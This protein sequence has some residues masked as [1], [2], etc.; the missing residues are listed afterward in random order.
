MEG[1]IE[2]S[3]EVDEYVKGIRTPG[4][5]GGGLAKGTKANRPRNTQPLV[6]DPG[7]SSRHTSDHL[8][9][10]EDEEP[11]RLPT[12]VDLA[13]SFLQTEPDQERAELRANVIK[14]QNL[15]QSQLSEDGDEGVDTGLGMGVSL[16]GFLADFLKGVG[17]RLQVQIRGIQIDLDLKIEVPSST[18][19]TISTHTE[20][21][22][23]RLSVEHIIIDGVITPDID[24]SPENPQEIGTQTQVNSMNYAMPHRR[25]LISNIRGEILSDASLFAN[26]SHLSGPPSPVMTR[27][28]TFHRKPRSTPPTFSET[29]SASSSSSAGLAMTQST[30]LRSAPRSP[31]VP[32]GL[33]ASMATSDGDRFAD[34]D[35]IDNLEYA[36]FGT[37]HVVYTPSSK[38]N[39]YSR[40]ESGEGQ[41]A[42]E[43]EKRVVEKNIAASLGPQ[44]VYPESLR[45]PEI[46]DSADSSASSL[47][48]RTYDPPSTSSRT[49]HFEQ[50][51]LFESLGSI[52]EKLG[53]S[54]QSISEETHDDLPPHEFG[55]PAHLSTRNVESLSGANS[56]TAHRSS[57]ASQSPS[58][59][60]EDLAQSKI[61][62]HDEAQSLYMSA[63]SH[64]SATKIDEESTIGGLDSLRS[65]KNVRSSVIAGAQNERED[66]DHPS[67]P[68]GESKPIAYHS[69][70]EKVSLRLKDSRN[71]EAEE[72]GVKLD[73]GQPSANL[74]MRLPPTLN[75]QVTAAQ[76]ADTSQKSNSSSLRSESP[77]RIVKQFLTIDSVILKIPQIDKD[78]QN[79]D[80]NTKGKS[81]PIKP[82]PK[83][84]EVPG[85][86]AASTI[87]HSSHSTIQEDFGYSSPQRT[88]LDT[89]AEERGTAISSPTT[90]SMTIVVGTV[91]IVSDM[92]LTRLIVSATQQ[93]QI[94]KSSD[95]IP[96]ETS[97]E[98]KASSQL[99]V[100]QADKLLWKF[101]D[102]LRGRIDSA[103]PKTEEPVIELPLE[104]YET[105][106][107][108][109]IKA[110][111][112]SRSHHSTS[113]RTELSI[114]SFKFGYESGNIVSFDSELKMRESTHEE[115]LPA[116]RDMAAIITQFSGSTRIHI[117][118]LPLLVTLDLARL[119][120]T[121]SWFGGLSSVLG[122]GS[123]MMSSVTVIDAKNKASHDGTRPRG[124]RFE[125]PSGTD[126]SNDSAE[127]VQYKVETRI[128]GVLFNLQG[129]NSALRLESTA[130]KLVSR[131]EYVA[132]QVDRLKLS[133]PHLRDPQG[134]PAIVVQLRNVRTEYLTNP[135]EVD[136]ARLLALLSP[137]R[138]KYEPDD[139][140][141]LDTLLRQRRQG[142]VIR[143]TVGTF[144]GNISSLREFEYFSALGEE[145]TKLST[146]TKYL[147]EDDRP[148]IL[149]L[150]LVRDLRLT[151]HINSNFGV[152]EVSSHNI[153]L[154][155]VT[156]PSLML[157]GVA[158]LHI[159]RGMHEE[160]IGEA[161]AFTPTELGQLPPMIM[162]RLI[163]GELE[164]TI[165]VKLWNVRAEYHVATIMAILGVSESTT[166]E[167]IISDLINSVATLTGR[168][169]PPKLASQTSSSSG[170]SSSGS[171]SLRYDVAIRD[172]IVGLNPRKS[173]SKAL[174]VLTNTK[175]AGTI[176]NNDDADTSSVLEIQKASLMI[177]DNTKHIITSGNVAKETGQ[178]GHI[179]Q[180]QFFARM[181]Y[182]SISEIAAAKVSLQMLSLGKEGD[183]SVDVEVRD[184]LF[185]LESCADST[186]TLISIL[187]GL[188]PPMPP[189]RDLKYRTEVI[190]VQ[191]MLASF[192]GNAFATTGT[193]SEGDD[194]YALE[195]EEEDIVDDEVPQN[196]EFVSSFYNP[197]HTSP[198]EAVAN[199][200]LEDDLNS[201]ASPPTTRNIGDKRLLE[202]F[203]EQYE[204]APGSEPLEFHEDHF[205]VGSVIGGTAHKWDSDRNS[206][207]LTNEFKIRGS[208]LRVRVRDVHIIWNL[209]DGYDWQ[210][211]RDIISQAVTEVENKAAERLSR[212]GRRKAQDM[213]EEEDSVIGDF[214]FNSIYI[215]VPA[216]RDPRDLTRQVNRNI[217]DLTSETGSYA[218]STTAT[219]SPNRQG[220]TKRAKRATLRLA[221]SK[222]HKM[223]FELK[224]VAVDLVVFAP[225]S[226]ETESS[227]DVRVQDLE[228]FDLVTTSTWR[229]FATYMHDAGERESGTSMVHIEILNVKP[230][231]DLAASEIILK[232]SSWMIYSSITNM[233]Q[234]TVLPLRLHVDQDALD[235][236]TRF[237]EFKDDSTLTTQ[238]SA[239][240]IPFLQRVEVNSIPVKLD[241]K[242]KRVDYAGI[243]SGHTTEFMNFFILDQADMV[244][245]HVIIYGVSGF[246][247]LGKTL[248]DIW[249]PDIKRNQLPG[250]LAG[251][252]P[253]RSLVNVGGGVR[254]LVVVPMREYRKDGRVMRSI[255]KGALSFAKTTTTELA[256]LG[257]KLALGTHTVLQNAEGFLTPQPVNPQR[258][259]NWDGTDPLDDDEKKVISLYAD[260][261]VGVVQGLRGAY[262]SLERDLLTAKDAIVAMPGEVMESGSASGAAKAVLRGAPT[263]ILRPALGVSKAVGQ[264]LLGATNSLDRG[265]R[266]RVEDVSASLF[267]FLNELLRL[268]WRICC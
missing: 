3:S 29:K 233:Y 164:P 112:L 93:L 123:S 91:S 20:H 183:R 53:E 35:D 157:L 201:I 248:N 138:D 89:R 64:T 254:D 137:S 84:F 148:G 21:V 106:L 135:K 188:K 235:F 11:G 105:L 115:S 168:P 217:D 139:D 111:D 43:A 54:E 80:I 161:M 30:I 56:V 215:G 186:Q 224:G 103:S 211:T 231:P 166:G 94:L 199:S 81:E 47:T 110:F 72:S 130:V 28:N 202:S 241:F 212:K 174:L 133:G 197:D 191:D 116:G 118:T 242:P 101:V 107:L 158:S 258:L 124:V 180:A 243:R 221:R 92:G 44:Y 250:V 232:V 249:M 113:S 223:T 259:D 171:K 38:D 114:G 206:Y 33:E 140:I 165:K 2:V 264:T 49:P 262:K 125:T 19:S 58:P 25:I 70:T 194:E 6:H 52:S 41:E 131:A 14:S 59:P 252:A 163:G 147:P 42:D 227:I 136:L 142:G 48:R 263:V 261:P 39:K 159:N 196:L 228:I 214:L 222:R 36:E 266:R 195:I 260:Q 152:A 167:I 104:N 247:K 31:G 83:S 143:V 88:K 129:K 162:A 203:Q 192:S 226:G 150:A 251:L 40:F 189:S 257:A 22:M 63:V 55:L 73:S 16:P 220:S 218:T 90:S 75:D 230:V 170:R 9:E 156:L 37:K 96:P 8:R 134:R 153:E 238:P 15:Q 126:H 187:N 229:K 50:L 32:S 169:P 60:S 216:N 102:V 67:N 12:T 61:Y 265:E 175:V 82:R 23:F 95:T 71:Y 234:A 24:T 77:S 68:F 17:D 210:H 10:N 132:V 205:G 46:S 225:G 255:S 97:H 151:A 144:E 65:D 62:S 246:D 26:F 122:I 172:S 209:F 176:P 13:R 87:S 78:V 57:T 79:Q 178:D 213:D 253:V 149:T 190:P 160:L 45:G 193:D 74:E 86:F 181:G 117:T 34:A 1:Q 5:R 18:A 208:P 120:E 239:S 4:G 237:F 99:L 179:S 207:N 69:E 141:L 240:E 109:T 85:A 66:F 155:Q 100:I 173:P 27:S 177:I 51:D 200:I 108:I 121:F 267:F 127:S 198:A 219:S 145:L 256:K 244:L 182:V 146:V 268:D 184:E 154:A 185:V 204:V 236:L 98:S 128:G 7:G 245:R 119:D 76:E